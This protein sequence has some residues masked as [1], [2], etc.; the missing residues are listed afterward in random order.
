MLDFSITMRRTR[1]RPDF[2][3]RRSNA[4]AAAAMLLT[5]VVAFIAASECWKALPAIMFV[6]SNVLSFGWMSTRARQASAEI[7][8]RGL[9]FSASAPDPSSRK[10]R[11]RQLKGEP[12]EEDGDEQEDELLEEE[13]EELPPTPILH[14]WPGLF[15]RLQRQRLKPEH[16]IQRKWLQKGKVQGFVTLPFLSALR[17]VVPDPEVNICLVSRREQS[18]IAAKA[19]QAQLDEIPLFDISGELSTPRDLDPLDPHWDTPLDEP[20]PSD[21]DLQEE[22]RKDGVLDR[23]HEQFNRDMEELRFLASPY[24]EKSRGADLLRNIVNGL[25]MELRT[26]EYRDLVRRTALEVLKLLWGVHTASNSTRLRW[27]WACTDDELEAPTPTTSLRGYFLL[28]GEPLEFVPQQHVDAKKA[29]AEEYLSEEQIRR[30]DSE[31]WARS[32]SVTGTNITE[33]LKR[34][35][36]GWSV[37]LKG[38]SWPKMTGRGAKYRLPQ[39]GKRMH[40]EIDFV[41][42]VESETAKE[43][44]DEQSSDTGDAQDSDVPS[45]LQWLGPIAGTAGVLYGIAKKTVLF[46]AGQ[47]G[48]RQLN[49]LLKGSP[50]DQ[51]GGD[52]PDQETQKELKRFEE[53]LWTDFETADSEPVVLVVGGDTETGQV[54]LRKLTTSG[55]H[56][57]LLKIGKPE[58]KITKVLSQGATLLTLTLDLDEANFDID[59]VPDSLYDAV[60]GVDKLVICD[61]DSAGV[62]GQV[63]TN[64]LLAWQAYRQDF[65]ECQR[66]Y[67]SKVRVFN[68]NRE[69][70]FDLWDLERQNPS[71]MSYGKQRG[72][73]TRNSHGRP[74]FIG[75]FLEDFAQSQLRSP[76]LKLNF[77][78]FGGLLIRVYNQAINRKYCLFLRTADFEKTRIQHEFEFQCKATCWHWVRMPF[79]AF[80]PIR[81]DG[82]EIPE[83]QAASH[84]F[85]REDVVQMGIVVRT[86]GEAKE[87]KE[88]RLHYYSLAIKDVK[89][90]RNQSEPQV[91]YVGRLPDDASAQILGISVEDDTAGSHSEDDRDESDLLDLSAAAEAQKQIA[92]ESKSEQSE[93]INQL[94][95]DT[96]EQMQFDE[97]SGATRRNPVSSI[98]A[99]V[100]SG[101][102]FTIFKV[103]DVN[104]EPGGKYPVTLQQ[105]PVDMP[106]LS[107]PVPHLHA[108]SRG[109]IA[110]I[111][112]SALSETCCVNAEVAVGNVS[113]EDTEDVYE[114]ATPYI[115][116]RS[117]AQEDVRSHLKHLVPNR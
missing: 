99:V 44:K 96:E 1:R 34:V 24:R 42:G 25:P 15:K 95:S 52:R 31:D 30:M 78:R 59:H 20:F 66:A 88:G 113:H 3:R 112:T 76:K 26:E 43:P 77:K 92:T 27:R 18:D 13:E 37:I 73:W 28:A 32:L 19:W 114:Q 61:S 11:L 107:L 108:V 79:N 75:H 40:I 16:L 101:L 81:T 116:I 21:E 63:V 49:E 57:V 55:C 80:K 14:K 100:R 83:D 115:E 91:V 90:Y 36:P 71:D 53:S 46:K 4:T 89:V 72:G 48:R 8:M 105:T 23:M 47:E 17:S 104:D 29:L 45:F 111:A 93:E 97:Q 109:D 98:A 50:P 60:A 86:N 2:S 74:M 85:S 62:P 39:S 9:T 12:E 110:A 70:D 5:L 51:A 65:A 103:A 41:Q 94:V 69:T 68:F 87:Y 6:R 106:H 82:V 58:K 10:E 35:P 56:C 67:S 84:P 117:T 22:L 33:A 7:S 102:A 54:I 38:D 64:V